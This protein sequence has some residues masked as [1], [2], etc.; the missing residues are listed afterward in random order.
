V[1][2]FEQLHDNGKSILIYLREQ[3]PAAIRIK[4]RT[5]TSEISSKDYVELV[6][7]T[8]PER[9]QA[10]L[11]R[12]ILEEGTDTVCVFKPLSK[13]SQII[14]VDISGIPFQKTADT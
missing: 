8:D 14:K 11:K 5:A 9:E 7:E 4:F 3:Y 6:F 10:F 13:K 1:S 2:Q 12:F